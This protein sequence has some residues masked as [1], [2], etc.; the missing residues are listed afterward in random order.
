M[1][2]LYGLRL[3]IESSGPFL[4]LLLRYSIAYTCNIAFELN[5]TYRLRRYVHNKHICS[6]VF[7]YIYINTISYKWVH[8][9][10]GR[11][12]T[13]AA[14]RLWSGLQTRMWRGVTYSNVWCVGKWV[15]VCVYMCYVYTYVWWCAWMFIY[16]GL[17]LDFHLNL[18]NVCVLIEAEYAARHFGMG[19]TYTICLGAQ[20]GVNNVIKFGL[21]WEPLKI[22]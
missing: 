20:W 18:F 22:V 14:L 4:D 19:C 15:W 10:N 21:I 13:F 3:R 5:S 11:R 1:Q 16:V 6:Y 9:H 7:I 12:R 17:G 8:K 2:I